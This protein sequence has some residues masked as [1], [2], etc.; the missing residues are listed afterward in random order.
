MIDVDGAQLQLIYQWKDARVVR[1]NIS[2][3]GNALEESHGV[4]T[5]PYMVSAS[6]GAVHQGS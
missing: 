3:N 6:L 1:Q 2:A 4:W 5:A